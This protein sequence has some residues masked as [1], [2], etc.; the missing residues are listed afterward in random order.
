[1]IETTTCYSCGRPATT[2]EHVPPKCFFP[3]AKDIEGEGVELRRNLI[4]VPS[5]AEHN[6]SRSRD[7]EYAMVVMVMHYETNQIARNHFATK[8]IRA[9]RRSPAFTGRVFDKTRDVRL[10]GLP[11]VSIDVD[12]DRFYGVMSSTVRGLIYHDLGRQVSGGVTVWSPVLRYPSFEADADHAG[13]AFDVRC[14][15]RG[16]P[17]NGENPDVFH[18]QLAA[19]EKSSVAARLVFYG[20]FDIYAL[21]DYQTPDKPSSL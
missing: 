11:T 14:V 20:G 3:E 16:S 10:G 18:Y 2:T 7:D 15:L 17:K 9:L 5:C 13:L 6:T 21:A 8:V 12:L 1:M 4:T 19:N